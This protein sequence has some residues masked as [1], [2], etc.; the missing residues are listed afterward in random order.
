MA[1]LCVET[2]L[3]L[4]SFL[5][6]Q[7]HLILIFSEKFDFSMTHKNTTSYAFNFQTEIMQK[8]GEKEF[9][10]FLVNKTTYYYLFL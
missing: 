7:V 8:I 3:C 5:Q 6:V 9:P 10:F 1:Y 4:I 2:V